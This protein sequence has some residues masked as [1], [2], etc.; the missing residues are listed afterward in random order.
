VDPEGRFSL[1]SPP[2]AESTSPAT[3]RSR[4]V[5]RIFPT[6]PVRVPSSQRGSVRP[7]C[8]RTGGTSRQD[9]CRAKVRRLLWWQDRPGGRGRPPAASL[10]V[11]PGTGP[12]QRV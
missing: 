6:S 1:A 9:G 7:R 10:P 12:V 5:L 3:P 11:L 2:H 8:E 4:I